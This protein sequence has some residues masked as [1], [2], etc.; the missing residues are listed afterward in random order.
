MK[1]LYSPCCQCLNQNTETVLVFYPERT[2]RTN[3]IRMMKQNSELKT[4]KSSRPL[5]WIVLV[6]LAAAEIVLML[7]LKKY[8]L[9][10]SSLMLPC[11]LALVLIDGIL[12]LWL[13]EAKQKSVFVWGSV[14]CLGSSLLCACVSWMLFRHPD[15]F[16][17]KI[18]V[19]SK[20]LVISLPESGAQCTADLQSCPVGILKNINRLGTDKAVESLK[21]Q[22]TSFSLQEYTSFEELVEAARQQQVKAV[23]LNEKFLDQILSLDADGYTVLLE[24][25]E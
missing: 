16:G 12:A 3:G 13:L 17:V 14:L 5:A 22:L 9:L 20:V 4:Q 2:T 24:V 1:P 23:I 8:R 11:G 18:P 15:L 19:P 7:L 21:Q 25:S 6:F 10:T